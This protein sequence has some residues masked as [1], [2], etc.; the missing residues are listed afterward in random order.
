MKPT[1]RFVLCVAVLLMGMSLQAQ[2]PSILEPKIE[3]LQGPPLWISAE[4]VADEQEI[5]NLDLLDSPSLRAYVEMQRRNLGHGLEKAGAGERPTV[6]D[7][8]FSEC[9]TSQYSTDQGHRGGMAP[10]STLSDL[11]A[12][13]LAILRGTIRTIDPGFDGGDPASLLGVEISKAIKG[14]APQPLV[15]V[16]YP[17]AHYKI[18]PLYFCNTRKGFEPSPGDQVL[19]F[20]N[21]GP[22]DREQIL[23]APHLKQILFQRGQ[24]GGLF[25]PAQLKSSPEVSALHTLDDVVGRLKLDPSGSEGSI[26]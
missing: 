20:D 11:A 25:L 19:F 16:L 7:I 6:V 21:T 24:G 2:T 10:A 18:G 13:S 22:V 8:P 12:N 14:S 3:R 5:I 23:F 1:C 17:V 26:R 9:P 15:Y 4:A